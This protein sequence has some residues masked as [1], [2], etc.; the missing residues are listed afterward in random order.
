M[1]TYFQHLFARLNQYIYLKDWS[2]MRI[3]IVEDDPRIGFAIFEDL[4][5]QGYAVDWAKEGLEALSLLENYPFDLCILD[6][7]IPG[8]DGFE[9][10]KTIRAQEQLLPILMLTARDAIDDR[11]KGLESGADD[12]LVKPFHLNEFRAR[13]RALLRRSRGKA[14]NQI[15]VGRLKLE[16]EQK[17]I[18]FADTEVKLS[19]TEY[20]LLEFLILHSEGTFS[21]ND[22]LEH[23]WPADASIDPRSV[24][25]YIRYLRRKLSDDVIETRRGL[26]YRLIG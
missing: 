18:F 7:M 19:L 10:T 17:R 21:R 22:L 15:T 9:I 24:D 25:T 26:G 5:E 16:L 1:P 6:I 12:Y 13:I 3:L 20:A 11:V 8:P 23:V 14:S 2:Y 4:K